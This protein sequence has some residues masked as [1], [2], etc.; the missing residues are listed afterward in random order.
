MRTGQHMTGLPEPDELLE[1]LGNELRPVVADDPWPRLGVLLPRSLQ[2]DLGVAFLH[3]LPEVPLDEIAAGAV[4]D[5]A[6]I[7][8]RAGD[9]DV[10]EVNVPTPRG[11]E[12]LQKAFGL[13]CVPLA[14]AMV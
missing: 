9:V 4:Q 6:Q 7:I 3:R 5:A 1:V 10:G 8:E 2:H 13:F 14:L 12:R 11:V